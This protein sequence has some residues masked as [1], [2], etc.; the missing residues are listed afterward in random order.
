MYAV[1]AGEVKKGFTPPG[2]GHLSPA[3]LRRLQHDPIGSWVDL[4]ARYGDVV[5]FRVARYTFFLLGRPEF[6]YDVFVTANGDHHKGL[7]LQRA[8]I[9]LG[10]GLLTSED[11]L[12]RRQRRL[13]QP[14]FNHARLAGYGEVMVRRAE[15][16]ADGIEDGQ[17][18][19]VAR[20][21]AG[22]T[23]G[24]V[25]E[26]LFSAEVE[27]E[28][29]EIGAALD[30]LMASF[31]LVAMPFA[32]IML[33]LPLRRTRRFMRAR[34]RLD[35]TIYR[36]IAERRR[37]GRDHGDLLSLLLLARDEQ[38]RPMSDEQARDEALTIFI[39]GHE[40]TANLLTWTLYLLSHHPA[41]ARR[42]EAE[43]DAVLGERSPTSADAPAL[44]YAGRVLDESLRLYPPAW[45]IGRRTLVDRELGGFHVPAGTVMI[46]SP[47]LIH[48]DPRFWPEPDRFDPD[49]P[50]PSRRLAFLP[51][52][53]GPRGCIG[54]GFALM[55]ARLLLAVLVR[56][57]RF[58]LVPGHPVEPQASITLRTRHGMCM[59]A[60]RRGTLAS[61]R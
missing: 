28:A 27:A 4:S 21:V 16:F 9:L 20:A 51:F 42:L 52:G 8:R 47:F 56:R 35:D 34:A 12:H 1:K 19:D 24:I 30:D 57:L 2:P 55:E 13:I 6:A 32:P 29:V 39:A 44:V 43:V 60:R 36:L 58:E 10:D 14:A 37:E 11:P 31:D 54:S 46:V 3:A 26:T 18:L 23:L 61:R 49:R 40:T 33:R 41:E 45:S 7:T 22:L 53:A 38:G 59:V 25:G 50:P 17:E 48:R 15:A 5:R